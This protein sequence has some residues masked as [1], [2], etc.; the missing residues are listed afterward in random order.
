MTQ[1]HITLEE[2]AGLDQ[3]VNCKIAD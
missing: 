1:I 3:I 2:T